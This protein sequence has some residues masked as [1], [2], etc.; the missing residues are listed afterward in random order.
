MSGADPVL[1]SRH[2]VGEAAAVA[3]ALSGAAAARLGE[4]RGLPGQRVSVDVQAAATSLLGFLFQTIPNGPDLARHRNATIAFYRAGDGRWIHL[5][6]GFPHLAEGLLALLGC[7]LDADAIAIASAVAR[8]GA[9]EL[10]DEVAARGLC[11]AAVRSEAEWAAH[12][13]GRALAALPVF[14]LERIGDA[15]SEPFEAAGR[16]LAGVRVLDLTRVL[17]GPT[18]GRTLA[19]HGAEVLRIGAERLPSIEPF[20]VETGRGKRNAFLDLDRPDDV[21]RLR[22]LAQ[23]CDVFCEGYRPGSLARRGFAPEAL[24]ALRPGV[25]VVSIDC[26]G[27][28]GPWAGRPGWEQLAQ[29]AVG[30][31]SAE[32]GDAAPRLVPAAPTDYTSGTLAAYGAMLALARRATEGGSWHV[33]ASLCQTGMWLTRLGAQLD[34][35][36]A[37]GLG[38]VS[39]RQSRTDTAWGRLSHLAPVV[40]LDHTPPHWE[41]PPAPLGAHAAA[42]CG[43]EMAPASRRAA[44]SSAE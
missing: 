22:E 3:L 33:R 34:P 20:V 23:D 31:A 2:P 1:Q 6:G 35:E 27:H 16:P 30:I 9:F 11:A 29:A 10:E 17:A 13:Q 4:L 40:G 15:E 28:V 21:R 42:W 25:V 5:H 38:D 36:A 44:I 18:C 43:Q 24:A 14:E 7:P 39:A 12:A 26:Y 19:E 37:A 32:G 41:L 8:H